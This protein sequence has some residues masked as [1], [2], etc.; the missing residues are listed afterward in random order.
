MT[1]STVGREKK[2]QQLHYCTSTQLSS[3]AIE[4][5]ASSYRRRSQPAQIEW[6]AHAH[7]HMAND[8]DVVTID[9]IKR[10]KYPY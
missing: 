2:P 3:S 1:K 9:Y 10:Y 8:D 4:F 7:T 5:G 6:Q